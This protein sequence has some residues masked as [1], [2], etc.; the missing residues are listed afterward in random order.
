MVLLTLS[1]KNNVVYSVFRVPKGLLNVLTKP[2]CLS[3]SPRG[4]LTTALQRCNDI[5]V[6]SEVCFFRFHIYEMGMNYYLKDF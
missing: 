6:A 2:C 5:F 1:E 4:L 3:T